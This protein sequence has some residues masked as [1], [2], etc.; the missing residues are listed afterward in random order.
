[1]IETHLD[2]VESSNIG[3]LHTAANE[4]IKVMEAGGWST[5]QC[6]VTARPDEG[7]IYTIVF[8]RANTKGIKDDAI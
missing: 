5:T 1:M 2:Y 7:Y 3:N 4:K 8:Q 6:Q